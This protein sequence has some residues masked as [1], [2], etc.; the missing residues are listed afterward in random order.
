MTYG[1]SFAM[2][3]LEDGHPEEALGLADKAILADAA[4]PEPQLDRAQALVALGRFAD[5]VAAIETCRALDAKARVIDDALL[6]DTLFSALV[7]WAQELAA[8]DVE[9]AVATL[10]R[11]SKILPDGT[12]ADELVTW[13]DRLRGRRET[14]AKARP[15]AQ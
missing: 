2:K 10:A 5:A 9:R 4:D 14:W 12:H 8:A 1:Q 13:T 11:Y 3:R 15:D 6:D 7:A